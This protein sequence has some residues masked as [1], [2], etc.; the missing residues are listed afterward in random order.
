MSENTTIELRPDQSALIID[1]DWT[2]RMYIPDS[3]GDD[4]DT[5]L[6]LRYLTMLTIK[7]RDEKFV[8]SMLEEFEKIADTIMENEEELNEE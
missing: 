2:V 5:P 6:S 8:E 1:E 7:T 3:I 4:D